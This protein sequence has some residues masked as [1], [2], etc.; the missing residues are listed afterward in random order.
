MKLSSKAK[1]SGHTADVMSC[2]AF[3]KSSSAR[4]SCLVVGLACEIAPRS[5]MWRLKL[6]IAPYTTA[7]LSASTGKRKLKYVR[8]RQVN[9]SL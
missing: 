3:V 7:S 8:W 2:S 4:P 6:T 9:Q 1:S 5:F